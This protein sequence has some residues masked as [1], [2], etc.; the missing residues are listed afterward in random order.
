M[1]DLATLPK[2]HLHVHIDACMR[3]S[4]L[5]ELARRDGVPVPDVDHSA[6]SGFEKFAGVYFAA[7]DVVRSED[8]LR[9]VV[10]ETVEDAAARGV[11]WLEPQYYPP[12][13]RPRLGP[14]EHQVEVVLDEGRRSASAHG[15]GFGLM[16]VGDRSRD[17]A[18]ALDQARLAA[19][20]A[21]DGVVAFG[22]ANDEAHFPPEP[23]ADAFR[24]ARDAG[25]LSTPHAGELAGPKSI[26]GALDALGADRIQHGVRAVEDPDLVRRLADEG[27][28]CDVCPTSNVLLGV[29]PSLE[30]H[31]LGRLLDAGVPCSVNADDPLLFETNV[32]E[33]YERCRDAMGFDD[34][35]L[36]AIA[37]TSIDASGAPDDLKRDVRARI[38]AWLH[39]PA[40]LGHEPAP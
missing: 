15:L 19:T 36:A 30:Q 10:R 12:D 14:D 17:V 9:R 34:A 33:E 21:G 39:D 35:R 16:L 6:S 18:L 8:D 3:P 22:L 7:C 1:R 24:V 27:I 32:A 37:R 5:R 31:P 29:V 20:Y 38:D 11:A 40:R 23:F 26:I 4:T 13:H 25:L 2:G 28:C